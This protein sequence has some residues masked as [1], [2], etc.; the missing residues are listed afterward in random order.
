MPIISTSLPSDG[1][2][3]DAADVNTPFNDI[4]NVVNGNLDSDNL[5]DDAVTA[6]KIADGA[7]TQDK[8]NAASLTGW[9]NLGATPNTVTYNGN[10]S[11]D[12]VFNSNDLTDTL[13]EGMRLKL[14]RTTTAPTQSTSLN[15]TTQYWSKSSPAGTTFTDD[16]CAGAWVYLTSYAI[17]GIV[18]RRNGTEGWQ[19]N[20]NASGQVE[21][22]GFNASLSNVS[23]VTSSQSIPLN[24]W[25]HIAAQLDMSAFTA[26]T[27]TSYI[28]IDGVDV[29][30][31]VT[32]GGTNPTALVQAGNL[33]IGSV[34]AA[35]FFPGKI[36]QAWYSSAKIT[37]ANIRT[38]M[39]QGITSSDISTHSIVSAFSFNGV[40]TDINT[41]NA[42]NLSASG[43]AGYTSDSPFA[44]GSRA[45]DTA[46]TTEHAVISTKP[47]FSTNTT[48]TVQV[49][50]GCAIPTSG[51]VNAVSYSTQAKPYGFPSDTGRWS[52]STLTYAIAYRASPVAATWYTPTQG[53]ITLPV[54]SWQIRMQGA[55]YGDRAAA[56]FIDTEI[57]LCTNNTSSTANTGNIPELTNRVHTTTADTTVTSVFNLVGNYV[58]A[59][60]TP[61]YR[62]VRFVAAGGVNVG[63]SYVSGTGVNKI[64][65]TP[66]F[67]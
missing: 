55:T 27:T 41:T 6:D 53:K 13:S 22:K 29:P 44:S 40:A 58:A 1:T 54:G 26:T 17:C 8:L 65:A 24:K 23:T 43:S 32:R 2:T 3:I 18:S 20:L 47:T 15:G 5:A 21:F 49:P 35:S 19:L 16:F 39:S 38:F 42:N 51:G 63:D 46:G 36:A 59:S 14:T 11:Y 30:A 9:L 67:L 7:V 57:T 12:L 66:N 37:Q 34:A 4:L 31:S 33:E 61:L 60:A 28:M 25:V 64:E 50:E 56:G 52:V 10:R 48:V 45:Y 62:K